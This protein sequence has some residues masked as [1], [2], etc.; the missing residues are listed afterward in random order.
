MSNDN[1]DLPVVAVPFEPTLA[2]PDKEMNALLD[3]TTGQQ[4]SALDTL[5]IYNQGKEDYWSF[6]EDKKKAEVLGIFL[7]SVRPARAFWHPDKQQ[8]GSPPECWSFDGVKPEAE[9][10]T[11]QA[12]A[13]Q[14]CKWDQLGTAKMGK[15]RACKTKA[16]DFLVELNGY[17]HMP[18]GKTILVDPATHIVG[19][20]LMRYSIANREGPRAWAAFIKGAKELSRPPQGVLAKWKWQTARNKSNIKYS[21]IDIEIIG[22]LCTPQQDPELWAKILTEVKN[23]KGGMAVQILKLLSGSRD[24]E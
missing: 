14:G 19:P 16:N 21:A 23:L 7:F 9:V 12:S 4:T 10:K 11:P 18:D 6:G 13:C 2:I 8:D 24:D 20:A 1:K 15:G 5:S 22:P 3:G 17:D